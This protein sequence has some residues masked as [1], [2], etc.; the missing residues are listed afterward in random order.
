MK[1]TGSTVD[2]VIVGGVYNNPDSTVWLVEWQA[3]GS[4]SGGLTSGSGDVALTLSDLLYVRN[5]AAETGT[6][7]LGGK[8]GNSGE[9]DM[10]ILGLPES[11]AQL[12]GYSLSLGD[13]ESEVR[14]LALSPGGELVLSGLS[15]TSATEGRTVLL[16]LNR[17]SGAVLGA[18]RAIPVSANTLNYGVTSVGQGLLC[19]GA[20]QSPN[21]NWNNFTPLTV[22]QGMS[23]SDADGTGGN[24]MTDDANYSPDIANITGQ[25]SL[26]TADPIYEAMAEMRELP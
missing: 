9:T 11:G 15:V 2:G 22:G 16:R 25:L 8:T 4:F 18:E 19:F 17:N 20:A 3:D 23:L 14:G 1:R 21:F 7:Y 6:Y 26:D 13:I 12:F 10:S 24:A 5:S